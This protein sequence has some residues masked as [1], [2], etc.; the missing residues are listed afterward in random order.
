MQIH[1]YSLL[2]SYLPRVPIFL[3]MTVYT[4]TNTHVCIYIYIYIYIK[5]LDLNYPLC[6][7]DKDR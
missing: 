1:F 5:R 7:L 4:H 3:A 6:M 2:W